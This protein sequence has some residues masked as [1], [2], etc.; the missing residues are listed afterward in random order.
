M[1]SQ[2]DLASATT[3]PTP[4]DASQDAQDTSQASED[5]R[6]FSAL[7]S[8]LD[9]LKER[10]RVLR[11]ELGPVRRRLHKHM[12]SHDLTELQCVQYVLRMDPSSEDEASGS[13]D[14]AEDE[15]ERAVFTK[16][17]VSDF[18]TADQYAAY[19]ANNRRPKRQRRMVCERRQDTESDTE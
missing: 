11:K 13:D 9:D 16:R 19:C 8:K 10:C 4:Q 15:G 7:Q 2:S 1:S 18:L 3:E 6:A 14:A 12:L 5:A 17:R